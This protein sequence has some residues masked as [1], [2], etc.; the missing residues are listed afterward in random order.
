M[1]GADI[2]FLHSLQGTEIPIFAGLEQT[3]ELAAG[4]KQAALV[5][6]YRE[7]SDI[8][9]EK[10]HDDSHNE[11]D[12]RNEQVHEPPLLSNM[13]DSYPKEPQTFGGGISLQSRLPVA[14]GR[15]FGIV[16]G[17]LN[18][19]T[20]GKPIAGLIWRCQTSCG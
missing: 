8:G 5:F 3:G 15:L 16:F 18:P 6:E 20:S 9:D 13:A 1:Q 12:E 14:K 11:D 4:I 10:K 19:G 2:D 17:E 7:P